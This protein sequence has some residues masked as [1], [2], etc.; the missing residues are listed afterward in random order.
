MA[1]THPL[2]AKARS[3]QRVTLIDKIEAE[4]CLETLTAMRDA[5]TARGELTRDTAA[6]FTRR[7]TQLQ[8]EQA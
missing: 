7:A 4:T 8:K 6:A 2:L 3:G 5:V 1:T